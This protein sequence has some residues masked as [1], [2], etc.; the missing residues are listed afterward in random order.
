MLV[1]LEPLESPECRLIFLWTKAQRVETKAQR[2]EVT[3]GLD[4]VASRRVSSSIT[5][6]RELLLYAAQ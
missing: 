5:P 4:D 1:E 3:R 6:T 2:V